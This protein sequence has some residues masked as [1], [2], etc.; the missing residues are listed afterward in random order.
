MLIVRSVL[1][2]LRSP[3]VS[4]QPAAGAIVQAGEGELDAAARAK[5]MARDLIE[6]HR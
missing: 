1:E 6:K 2:A 4:V 5:E 3:P